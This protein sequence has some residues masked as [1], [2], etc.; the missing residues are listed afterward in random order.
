MDYLEKKAIQKQIRQLIHSHIAYFKINQTFKLI[1]DNMD[2]HKID[3]V[4][5]ELMEKISQ[6]KAI[7]FDMRVYPDWGGFIYHYIYKYFSPTENYFGK[8]YRP[9]LK[10]IGTFVYKDY[11]YFPTIPNKTTHHYPGK[12]FIIVSTESQSASEWY[13]MNLQHIFPH[14]ITMGQKTAGADG[15]VTKVNLPG[16]YLLEFT[17]NG[18]FYP[19]HSQTQQTGIRVDEIITYKDKDILE[20]RDLEFERIIS[21]LK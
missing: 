4:M 7:V 9:N 10:N 1:D 18:I 20:N 5:N 13:T 16:D 17:G 8:Y 19:D 15:D 11:D 3:S 14:A 2:D 6:K 12:V 21:L